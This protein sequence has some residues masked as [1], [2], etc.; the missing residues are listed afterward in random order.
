MSRPVCWMMYFPRFLS[1]AKIIFLSAG[2]EFTIL[3]AFSGLFK[4]SASVSAPFCSTSKS[5]SQENNPRKNR[6]RMVELS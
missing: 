4:K 3:T 5:D 6:K 1:G 2:T